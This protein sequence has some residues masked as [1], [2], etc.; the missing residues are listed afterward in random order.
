MSLKRVELDKS[1]EEVI[2]SPTCARCIHLEDPHKHTCKAYPKGI[3]D[4][5]WEGTNDHRKSYPGDN[6]IQ[7]ALRLK[8]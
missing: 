8:E 3:P 4:T 6:G 7:F 1:F 5:I 2:Y